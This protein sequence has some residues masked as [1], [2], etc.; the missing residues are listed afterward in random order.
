[1]DIGKSFTFV[2][3]D[4]D[5]IVKILI[6]AG[7]FLAG[8]VVGGLFFWV[9][10]IPT[11]LAFA[12]PGGYALQVTRRVIGGRTDLLPEWDNWGELFME[13]VK[14]LVI[15][16]VYYL[17]QIVVSVILGP[18]AGVL[19]DQAEGLSVLVSLCLSCFNLIWFL[20]VSL[21]LPAAIGLYAENGELK[22]AFRFGEV[23][24]L[25]RDHFSTYLVTAVMSWVAG[26]IGILGTIVCGVGALVTFPYA[27]LVTGHLYGQAYLEA[28]G[29]LAAPAT[30]DLF[31]EAEIE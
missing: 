15:M 22:D 14:L 20:V 25:V 31:D 21:L 17:P 30:V 19:G 18:I 24:A 28:K 27:W 3:E 29:Q 5:W 1:M 11:I 26:I 7:I 12:L 9:I 13:G 23:I 4:E 2:F 16:F 10:L 6:A 8:L